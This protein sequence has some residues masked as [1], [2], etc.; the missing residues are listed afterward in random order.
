MRVRRA[1]L[2]DLRLLVRHRR[3]MW[4]AVAELHAHTL[5]AADRVY[6]RWARARIRSG[7]LV[8]FIIDEAGTAVASGC[9]WVMNVQPRPNWAGTRVAYLLSMFTEPS[10]RGKGHATRIVRAAVSWAKAR[11]IG[12]MLLHAS[13]FG[14]PIYRREGFEPTTEM[15]RFLSG[16]WAPRRRPSKRGP[17]SG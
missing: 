5:D 8:G 15:R 6:R 10:H 2:K 11:G 1:T 3:G 17:P 13:R 12:V 16:P 7:R 4:E 9:V 14:E